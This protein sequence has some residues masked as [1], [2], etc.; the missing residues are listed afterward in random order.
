M[1]LTVGGVGAVAL[2]AVVRETRAD[3]AVKSQWLGG[4]ERCGAE[5]CGVEAGTDGN[6]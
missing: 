3:V 2:K 1:A 4:A 5:R 6:D